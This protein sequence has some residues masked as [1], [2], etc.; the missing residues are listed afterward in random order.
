MIYLD[1]AATSVMR[2][3]CVVDAV[4]QALTSL[5]NPGRGATSESLDAGRVVWECREK[6]A[7]LLGCPRADHVCFAANATAALNA[8][9][10]GLVRPGARVVTTVT[11]HNSVLRPLNR[12][13]QQAGVSVAHAGVDGLGLLDYEELGRLCSDGVDVVVASHASN[14]T[15][16][17]A[18]LRRIAKI[19]HAA[20]AVLVVDASQSAGCVPISMADMDLDVVC[21]T[22]HKG[23]MGPQGTGGLTAREGI[24]V[25]PWAEGGSGVQSFSPMQPEEWP[26][27]LEAGT[28]NA[29]GI[30]GL[31]AALDYLR[32]IGGPSVVGEKEHSLSAAF[33]EG[34]RDL[35][36]V[37][38]YGDL[39][40]PGRAGIVSLNVGDLDSSEVSDILSQDFG[41]QTRP[42]AHCAP[43]MHRALGTENQGCVRF[44]FGWFNTYDDVTAAI[45]ALTEIADA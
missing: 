42:G 19:A 33:A 31:S 45:Q 25:R 27:R 35:P 1:N 24:D 8:A 2:P 17:V 21:F 39:S 23:L 12:L 32:R 43:L 34:V 29:H 38:L 22:G 28:L 10:H 5:G 20:G 30:A 16:N 13:A 44:S 7:A 41:I 3:Q 6:V 40:Q 18:D 11:E 37:R 15:G 14:V 4:C 26:T 9:I 36:G